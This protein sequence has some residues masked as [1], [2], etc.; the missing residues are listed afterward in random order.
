MGIEPISVDAS[1]GDLDLSPDM[2]ILHEEISAQAPKVAKSPEVLATE[3]E[4]FI[5]D[6]IAA[7]EQD[8]VLE[9]TG[10]KKGS[11]PGSYIVDFMADYSVARSVNPALR[12]YGKL[13]SLGAKLT[14]S[15][16]GLDLK[17]AK[18]VFK[19]SVTPFLSDFDPA[20]RKASPITDLVLSLASSLR[21]GEIQ[22]ALESLTPAKSNLP[23][24]DDLDLVAAETEMTPLEGQ[25]DLRVDDSGDLGFPTILDEQSNVTVEISLNDLSTKAIAEHLYEKGV[26]AQEDIKSV[27]VQERIPKNRIN[28]IIGIIRY[29]ALN[30]QMS[31]KGSL[32]GNL[33]TG[34]ADFNFEV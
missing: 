25:A 6:L 20:R 27:L 22:R 4:E 29:L 9:L 19:E 24:S 8:T 18:N 30:E 32:R 31:P 33:G 14:S 17:I 11:L 13:L 2:D 1:E 16:A 26:T 5:L 3:V 34:D 28:E 7:K 10:D 21:D 15:Q 23:D 12:W